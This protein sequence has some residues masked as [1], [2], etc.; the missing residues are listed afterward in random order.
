MAKLGERNDIHK[1]LL[2]QVGCGLLME[3][4]EMPET[5]VVHEHVEREPA[6]HHLIVHRLRCSRI[7][8]I[9]RKH[10]GDPPCFTYP[11]SDDLETTQ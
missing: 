5:S 4:S 10:R 8:E 11:L 9:G 1:K 6:S 2:G 3:S 7:R